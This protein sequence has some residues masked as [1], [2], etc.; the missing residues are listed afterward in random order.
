MN[1]EN[2]LYKN[3]N[4]TI[5]ITYINKHLYFLLNHAIIIHNIYKKGNLHMNLNIENNK[6]NLSNNSFSN[7]LKNQVEKTIFF[8]I[9]RFEGDF[10]ICENKTTGEM[11]NIKKS[12]LPESSKEGDIIKFENG[13][14]II[15][16]TATQNAQNEIKNMVNNLFNKN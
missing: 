1:E 9:D 5:K 11:V 10:A 8:S 15:D 3:I 7:E 13:V 14:Y 2:V 6:K 16:K 12:L 4:Y